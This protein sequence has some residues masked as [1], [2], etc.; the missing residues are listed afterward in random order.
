MKF[1]ASYVAVVHLI[2]LRIFVTPIQ[3]GCKHVREISISTEVES[4][5]KWILGVR[6]ARPYPCRGTEH[7]CYKYYLISFAGRLWP[8]G[9]VD[10]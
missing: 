2:L 4:P 9:I 10:F 3:H 5:A 8:E 6:L 1:D 7:G